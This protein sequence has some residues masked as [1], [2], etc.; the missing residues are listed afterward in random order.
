MA[1][2]YGVLDDDKI[3]M[4]SMALSTCNITV[5]ERDQRMII[6][7]YAYLEKHSDISVKEII[8]MYNGIVKLVNDGKR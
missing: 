5:S 3:T 6:A 4:V 2:K 7:L 8:Y 1:R